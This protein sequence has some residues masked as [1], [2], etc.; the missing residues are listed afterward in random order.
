M[1]S[2]PMPGISAN[3]GLPGESVSDTEEEDKKAD[4]TKRAK[5]EKR[6]GASPAP[7]GSARNILVTE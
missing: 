5:R 4:R 6:A 7:T 3:A 2:T 1:K